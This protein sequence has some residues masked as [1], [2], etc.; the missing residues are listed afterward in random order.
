MPYTVLYENS[1]K[2]V[3]KKMSQNSGKKGKKT[4]YIA[5][6]SYMGYPCFC[7]CV[8]YNVNECMLNDLVNR[9]AN[10]Q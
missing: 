10:F 4:G 1:C 8:D 9:Y 7:L 3:C 5:E 2:S 6:K